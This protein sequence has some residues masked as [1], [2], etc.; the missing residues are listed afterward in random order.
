MDVR[1]SPEQRALLETATQMVERLGPRTVR[2]LDDHERVAKLDAAVSAS[3]WRE[4]RSGGDDGAPWT[5]AVEVALVAEELA[6]GLADAAF[7]GPVLAAD[8]RRL[9]GAPQATA[10]ET[11]A[12]TAD[13][14]TPARF[15]GTSLTAAAVAFDAAGATTGLVLTADNVLANVQLDTGSGGVDLTR[16]TVALPSETAVT[17]LD[18]GANDADLARWTA[19]GL[20]LTAAELVGTMR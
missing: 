18:G 7:V 19:L 13:L 9:A 12:F 16:S 20:A 4:L 14:L 8:L 15:D 3:G 5:S 17:L 1:L 2:D 10:P 11:V 6:R